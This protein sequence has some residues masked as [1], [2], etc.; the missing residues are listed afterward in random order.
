MNLLD[1]NFPAGPRILIFAASRDKDAAGML[2]LI[3]PRFNR[4]LFARF[5]NNP[6]SCEP[7]TMLELANQ[8]CSE[9]LELARPELEICLDPAAAWRRASELAS[10]EHLICV[11][12]S[13]YIAAEVQA[14]RESLAS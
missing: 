5:L 11:T 3:L 4:V 1:E 12:G 8:I 9:R 13:F 14:V 2:R 10:P 6:R 7:Q